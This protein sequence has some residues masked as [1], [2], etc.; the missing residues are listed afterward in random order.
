MKK[1]ASLMMRRR[2]IDD[3]AS[4]SDLPWFSHSLKQAG[5]L[6]LSMATR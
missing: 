4:L 6:F 1:A 5:L 3:A 2:I